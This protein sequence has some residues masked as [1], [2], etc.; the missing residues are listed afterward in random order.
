MAK[1][2]NAKRLSDSGMRSE[3]DQKEGRGLGAAEGPQAGCITGAKSL[4]GVWGRCPQKLKIFYHLNLKKTPQ[5][6][7]LGEDY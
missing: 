6:A 1:A 3:I 7:I 5:N 2:K 4:L